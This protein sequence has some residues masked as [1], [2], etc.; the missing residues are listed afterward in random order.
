MMTP[1]RVFSIGLIDLPTDRRITLFNISTKR[2][3]TEEH[4]RSCCSVI[5]H[6]VMRPFM[7]DMNDLRVAQNVPILQNI[8]KDVTNTWGVSS[9]PINYS[10]FPKSQGK[11]TELA[12]W[13][14]VWVM[15]DDED[16]SMDNMMECIVY[17]ES[18]DRL[19][20]MTSFATSIEK[21]RGL[22]IVV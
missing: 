18:V 1:T 17:P 11:P 16:Q 6:E 4:I 8:L 3:M 5:E 14:E 15:D 12:I 22:E 21:M 9:N 19:Q 10:Y 7:N 13:W 20:Y 2:Q